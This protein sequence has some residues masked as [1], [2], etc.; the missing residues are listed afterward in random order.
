MVIKASTDTSAV[1]T[2]AYSWMTIAQ[3]RQA[4]HAIQ[5]LTCP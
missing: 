1:E 4:L 5:L 2:A 3:D